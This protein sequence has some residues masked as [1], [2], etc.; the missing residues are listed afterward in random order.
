[1]PFVQLDANGQIIAVYSEPAQGLVEM[2]ADDPDLESFLFQGDDD[3]QRRRNLIESDLGL[4]RVLI[5]IDDRGKMKLSMK[6]IDQE[7]GAD[8]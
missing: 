2:S 6:V 3:A 8:I 4:A 1:M 5:G 7:T